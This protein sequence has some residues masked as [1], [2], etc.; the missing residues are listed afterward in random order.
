MRVYPRRRGSAPGVVGMGKRY[1]S[2]GIS[3]RP[4]M[5]RRFLPVETMVQ[6]VPDQVAVLDFG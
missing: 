6:A 1:F 2:H 4:S 3:K 5:L